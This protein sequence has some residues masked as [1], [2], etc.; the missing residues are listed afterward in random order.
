MFIPFRTDRR[1]RY[2]PWVNYCLITAN[3]IIFILTRN[4][5][6]GMAS[7][8][9]TYNFLVR[10]YP[11]LN[12]FLDPKH[13]SVYQFVTSAFLHADVWHLG[14]NMLF[15]W[16]FGNSVEDRLGKVGYLGFYLTGAVV[17]GLGHALF[18]VNPA[19]GASGAVCAVT[20]IYLA[21][22]PMTRVTVLIWI[23]IIYF[24]E[25]TSLLFIGFKVALDFFFFLGGS[26]GVAYLAHLAGYMI[27]FAIGMAMLKT[28]LLPREPYDL[29]S[30]IEH[31]RR[32]AQFTSLSRDG[33]RPWEGGSSGAPADGALG[34]ANDQTSPEQKKIMEMRAEVSS[35]IAGGQLDDA[36][37][38]YLQL[39]KLDDQQVM[40]MQ[41]QYELANQL[42]AQKQYEWA[43]TAYERLLQFYTRFNERQQVQLILALIYTR[44]LNKPQRATE[45]LDKLKDR[46]D[47]PEHKEMAQ[48]LRS[49]INEA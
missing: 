22:F 5:I 28:R 32:R 19:I 27:G 8:R 1:L 41:Q 12:Y 25:V 35:A 37:N 42:M 6:Q 14:F 20:G 39:L 43:A 7:E 48:Q 47:Q 46:L 10:N 11:V 31:R 36:A 21:L 16:V 38:R 13:L 40:G 34:G 18:E 29:L 15:L 44:Y 49:E 4:Q 9:E 24:F 17:S 26:G 2:T 33:Y 45:L 3:V 23:I 30:M